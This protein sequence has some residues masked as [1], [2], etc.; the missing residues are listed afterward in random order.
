VNPVNLWER[1]RSIYF[2]FNN[3]LRCWIIGLLM[4]HRRLSSTELAGLLR[5]NLTRCH[6]HLENLTSFV[7]QDIEKQYFL[8][9]EGIKAFHFLVGRNL[10]IQS[11]KSLKGILVD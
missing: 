9:E 5:I 11:S 8:S 7:K 2:A 4:S 1:Q 10:K 6:Y 3:P